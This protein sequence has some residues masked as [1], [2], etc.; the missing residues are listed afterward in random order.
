MILN[1]MTTF[2][3]PLNGHK[4]NIPFRCIISDISTVF[5][6]LAKYLT[7]IH[8]ALISANIYT[9][10][11]SIN[12][13]KVIQNFPS[14]NLTMVSVPCKNTYHVKTLLMIVHT[15]RDLLKRMLREFHF[16]YF[17]NQVLLSLLR[18]RLS[19]IT[20]SFHGNF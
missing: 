6:R 4:S 8:D 1:K 7:T 2:N 9:V 5:Y 15:G 10:R 12:F 11:N 17:K 13:V 18:T 20:F 16:R 19:Q 3:A 14:N